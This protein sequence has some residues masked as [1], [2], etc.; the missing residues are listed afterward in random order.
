MPDDCFGLLYSRMDRQFASCAIVDRTLGRRRIT[1]GTSRIEYCCLPRA[2]NRSRLIPQSFI[3]IFAIARIYHSHETLVIVFSDRHRIERTASSSPAQVARRALARVTPGSAAVFV[4]LC[5]A[6]GGSL[7]S[8]A[9]ASCGD[10][11][12]LGRGG[13]RA[14]LLRTIS[15]RQGALRGARRADLIRLGRPDRFAGIS[16]D[17]SHLPCPACRRPPV[18]SIPPAPNVRVEET[19]PQACLRGQPAEIAAS[20]RLGTREAPKRPVEGHPASI[21]HPPKI[22]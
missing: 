11:V 16:D 19:E 9:R 6:L 8:S 12:V 20:S 21:D 14:L 18:D 1:Y 22:S 7:E 4:L 15:E 2:A 13:Q 10:Y 17:M 5:W 3:I